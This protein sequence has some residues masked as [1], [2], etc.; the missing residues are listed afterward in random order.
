M[1]IRN[2]LFAL[3]VLLIVS[4]NCI[5][6]SNTIKEL[7]YTD[8]L[9]LVKQYHP[10]AKQADLLIESADANTLRARGSFDPKLFYD[11]NNKF[12]DS[13]TYYELG[14]GGFS[15]PTWFGVE[16][17]GGYEQNEGPFLNPENSL[18]D[19]GLLYG[20][21]SVPLLQGLI[22]DERRAALRQASLFVELSE[23]EKINAINEL[24]YKAGKAYWD[25][26]LAYLNV[27][28]Y[29]N[30]VDISQ[31][32][33]NAIVRTSGLG[34]RPAIDTVEANIQLQDRTISLEQSLLEYRTKTLMLSNFLW[35]ENNT[36]IELSESTIPAVNLLSV[37]NDSSLF[38]NVELLDSLINIHPFL[39][40]YDLKLKQ[41][42]IDR[43]LKQDKLK[44]TLDLNYTPLL[45]SVNDSWNYENNYKFGL[46]FAFPIFLR[47]ERGDLRLAKI[48]LEN[49]AY[50]S[51]NKRNELM[52]KAKSM[53][54]EFRI[55]RKQVDIYNLNIINYERLYES[56]KKLFD[57]GE[58][59]LFMINSREMSF[60]NAQ[61]KLNEIVN[62][63]RKA[64]L[65][66]EYSY[67]LLNAIY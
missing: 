49:T 6:Q 42:D 3:L 48:K 9:G 18:P 34:D 36:P 21:V 16:I 5:A 13:K 53:I 17:K 58:S 46:S 39:K 62:K 63:S 10:M 25:W 20:R 32:R 56:E 26:Q 40:V 4:V 37:Q 30:A 23:V 22:I 38:T 61:V 45:N 44:P 15:I 47:K 24:L 64:T 41:L 19:E 29:Q 59:S 60:I 66:L 67:G 52:N 65:D 54:N 31:V 57:L 27:K 12:Y 1:K 51:I 28:V 50:D 11:F 43:R 14:N 7:S 35:I 55:Y 2:K 33:F 8:F